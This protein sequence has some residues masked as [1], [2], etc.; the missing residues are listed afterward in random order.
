M[1]KEVGFEDKIVQENF[2]VVSCE[3]ST[4]NRLTQYNGAVFSA[5]IMHGAR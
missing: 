5:G 3:S 1:V 4:R 2:D